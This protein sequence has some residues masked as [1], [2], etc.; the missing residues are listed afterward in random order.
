MNNLYEDYLAH[1]GVKGQKWGVRRYQ[2]EDGTL[3]NKG[4]KLRQNDQAQSTKSSSTSANDRKQKVKKILAIGA[5]VAVAAALGY[6][7]YKGAKA[8]DNQYQTSLSKGIDPIR[9]FQKNLDKESGMAYIVPKGS[10]IQRLSRFDESNAKGHAYV[11]FD[12]RDNDRYRGFF[13][14]ILYGSKVA[15]EAI[16]KHSDVYVHDLEA[17]EDL[18]SPSK[19][20]RMRTFLEMYKDNPVGVGRTLGNYHTKEHGNRGVMPKAVYRRQYSHLKGADRI[21]KGYRTFVKAIGDNNNAELRDECFSRLK[22]KGYNMIQDDQDS[23]KNGYR[24]SIVFDRE[25]SLIY[26]GHRDLPLSE[27]KKNYRAYG[28]FIEKPYRHREWEA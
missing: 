25:Q 1:Y 15:E 19:E 21:T 5:G 12:Q 27:V 23:G 11:T 18:I 7:A 24:P 4:K 2:N 16:G 10:K 3:T 20:T 8:V 6:A 17:K 13:G 9:P 14:R 28:R 26:I 22:A